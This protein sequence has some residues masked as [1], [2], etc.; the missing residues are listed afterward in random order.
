MDTKLDMSERSKQKNNQLID[1]FNDDSR[2]QS[3][4][5]IFQSQA[6]A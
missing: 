1:L 4:L 5:Y 6:F 2:E 3:I